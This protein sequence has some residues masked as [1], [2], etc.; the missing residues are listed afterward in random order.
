MKP[1]LFAAAAAVTLSIQRGDRT[2][3]IGAALTDISGGRRTEA[4]PQAR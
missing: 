1:T 3:S 2:A 4:E